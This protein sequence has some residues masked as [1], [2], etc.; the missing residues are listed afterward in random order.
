MNPYL[1]YE[2]EKYWVGYED[3]ESIMIKVNYYFNYVY[4]SSFRKNS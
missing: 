2:N 3:S 1:I 4:D